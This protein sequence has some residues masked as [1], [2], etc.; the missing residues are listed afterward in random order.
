M[1]TCKGKDCIYG[2]CCHVENCIYHAA[3]DTCTAEQIDV[4]SENATTKAET[5]CGTF[6]PCTNCL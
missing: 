2:I 3:G 1:S 4:K 5:F 6:A